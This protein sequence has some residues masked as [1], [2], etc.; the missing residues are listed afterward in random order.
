MKTKICS[1]C[2]KE[3]D[4]KSFSLDRTKKDGAQTF[5]K[6]CKKELRRKYY[7]KN[8]DMILKEQKAK[9]K[10]RLKLYTE[11]KKTLKCEKCDENR[12]YVLEFHHRDKE[13]KSF[14]IGRIAYDSTVDFSLLLEEIKK[15]DVLCRNCHAELHY[16]ENN[17]PID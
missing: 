16:L 15:C 17:A 8:K 1:K 12:W 3:K 11:Y 14:N 7:I 6:E 4:I 2:K 5:C 13:D 9:R 10:D